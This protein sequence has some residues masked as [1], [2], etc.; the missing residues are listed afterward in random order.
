MKRGRADKATLSGDA[1]LVRKV[2]ERAAKASYSKRIVRADVGLADGTGDAVL[3]RKQD[4][5]PSVW[6]RWL[7]NGTQ[8]PKHELWHL[9]QERRALH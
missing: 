3:I 1:G 5:A 9:R 8:G 2:A 6:L 4:E 7:L